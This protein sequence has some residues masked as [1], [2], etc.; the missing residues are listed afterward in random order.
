MFRL[1][2]ATGAENVGPRLH[3]EDVKPVR[4]SFVKSLARYFWCFTPRFMSPQDLVR[5]ARSVRGELGCPCCSAAPAL[6]LALPFVLE[7]SL[8]FCVLCTRACLWQPCPLP[9]RSTQRDPRCF[10]ETGAGSCCLSPSC[11]ASKP[12]ACGWLGHLVGPPSCS[13]EQVGCFLCCFGAKPRTAPGCL[14][15]L[16]EPAGPD[17]CQRGSGGT[18]GLCTRSV[19]WG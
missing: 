1:S 18:R 5:R 16:L 4:R 12:C 17:L 2:A 7:P 8:G 10:T 13:S 19:R 6:P 11:P 15:L 9:P 3:S 14:H